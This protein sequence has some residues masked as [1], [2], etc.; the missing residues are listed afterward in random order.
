MRNGPVSYTHLDVYKRQ[1]DNMGAAITRGVQSIILAID[2]TQE[3]LNR[4][5]MR[6]AIKTFGSLLE[7]A[8]KAVAAVLP[9]VIENVDI[10]AIS[11]AGLMPVSYTHLDVYKRQSPPCGRA[12]ARGAA[13]AAGELCGRQR[14]C[15]E[16]LRAC[17]AGHPKHR[18]GRFVNVGYF[19]LLLQ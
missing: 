2:D 8:L 3:A 7:K 15:R 9:P 13:R 19:L 12:G 6:D 11:V 10:L 5:T 1:F 16:H 18:D 4:P 14:G 17:H